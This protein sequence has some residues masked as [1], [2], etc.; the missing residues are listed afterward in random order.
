MFSFF[1]CN[2]IK[3]TVHINI[4]RKIIFVNAHVKR[5]SYERLACHTCDIGDEYVLTIVFLKYGFR[6]I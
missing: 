6:K 2:Y 3:Q 5:T 4:E 1:L